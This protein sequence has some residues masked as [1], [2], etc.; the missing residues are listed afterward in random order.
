MKTPAARHSPARIIV[1]P[2]DGPVVPSASRERLTG[3]EAWQ[4]VKAIGP[5]FTEFASQYDTK[6]YWPEVYERVRWEFEVRQEF[7]Q[8]EEV[9]SETLREALLWKYVISVSRPFRRRTRD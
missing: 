3:A 1:Q 9:S 7:R 4:I 8:P 5:R 2:P 6:K